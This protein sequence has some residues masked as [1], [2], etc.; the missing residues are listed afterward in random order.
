MRVFRAARSDWV[1][2][3]EENGDARTFLLSFHRIG[4]VETKFWIPFLIAMRQAA[5][6]LSN[7]FA[8]QPNRTLSSHPPPNSSAALD[9]SLIRIFP[10]FHFF[11]LS[12]QLRVRSTTCWG[13]ASLAYSDSSPFLSSSKPLSLSSLRSVAAALSFRGALL[14]MPFSL[15]RSRCTSRMRDTALC[16]RLELIRKY[17]R[18][19]RFR[20]FVSTRLARFLTKYT[21]FTT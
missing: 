12:L 21:L 19:S 2:V 3:L 20:T 1:L 13:S 6:R 16:R 14:G 15:S 8:F 5:Q 11:G 10:L 4:F 17:D 7:G 18:A 9:F